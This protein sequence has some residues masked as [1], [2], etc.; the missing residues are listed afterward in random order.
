MTETP[1]VRFLLRFA[2]IG[3]LAFIYLPIIVLAI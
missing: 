2:S 1:L 3:V